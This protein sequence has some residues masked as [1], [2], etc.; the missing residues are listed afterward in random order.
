M[1]NH[2]LQSLVDVAPARFPAVPLQDLLWLL[3]GLAA[4]ELLRQARAERERR[5]RCAR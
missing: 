2:Q 4:R 1:K 5:Q 3:I